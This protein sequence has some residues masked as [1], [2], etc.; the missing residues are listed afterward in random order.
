[1]LHTL[2]DIDNVELVLVVKDVVFTQICMNQSTC[3]VHHTH[4]SK[5][6]H[7]VRAPFCLRLGDIEFNILETR[8]WTTLGSSHESHDKNVQTQMDRLGRGNA[9]RI[10]SA[11]VPHFLLCPQF[12]H[13]PVVA[14]AVS[15]SEPELTGHILFSV[16]ENQNACLVNL[17][18]TV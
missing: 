4:V 15:L 2:T 13:R 3:L 5:Q 18:R 16:L 10:D 17:D 11:Q 9:R 8:C 14:L 1:M 6:F 7:V 12:H